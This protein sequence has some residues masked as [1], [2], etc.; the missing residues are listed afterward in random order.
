MVEP[1][2]AVTDLVIVNYDKLRL[3]DDTEIANLYS[4]CTELG[5]FF[6][7][8]GDRTGGMLQTT[9]ELFRVT[10]EY[11][12]KSLEEKLK[13]TRSE[14]EVFHICGYTFQ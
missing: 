14:T 9:D 12:A 2:Y 6:L 3:K 5:F 4:A 8:L 13:D 10:K 7:E 11:F 1:D